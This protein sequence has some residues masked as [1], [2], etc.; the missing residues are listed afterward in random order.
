MSSP[1]GSL[2][3][4]ANSY[5]Q[6]PKSSPVSHATRD[7]PAVSTNGH[8]FGGYNSSASQLVFKTS[9]FY[10]MESQLGSPKPCE[11]ESRRS[12]IPMVFELQLI[13][14]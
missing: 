1:A 2:S 3:Q 11:G 12:Y 10:R 9:P 6:M 8:R 13:A 7:Y 4:Y 5:N 14:L